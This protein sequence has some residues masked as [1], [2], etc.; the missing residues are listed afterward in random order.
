MPRVSKIS[1]VKS[2]KV[3][4]TQVSVS[5]TNSIEIGLPQAV[6]DAIRIKN[7]TAHITIT[8]GVLQVSGSEPALFIPVTGFSKEDFV[9]ADA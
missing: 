4:A 7:S 1:T 6:M 5:R 8:N 2:G 9:P 3:I